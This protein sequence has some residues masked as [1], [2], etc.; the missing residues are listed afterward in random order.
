MNNE[1]ISYAQYLVGNNN[2]LVC[3]IDTAI[4]AL[5][6]HARYDMSASGGHFVFTRWEDETDSKPPTKDEIFAELEYQ[7]KF[8]DYWQHFIDRATHYPDIVVL[9]NSLW[10]GIDSGAI[11]GKETNFYKLIK[12]VNDEFPRPEGDPPVRPTHE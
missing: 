9:I 5:R 11:P 3:G 6:P 2:K 7:N 4:K 1:D 8:V 10:E 12:E